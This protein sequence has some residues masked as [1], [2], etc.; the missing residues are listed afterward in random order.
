LQKLK[1]EREKIE[2]TQAQR[3]EEARLNVRGKDV[4]ML[5]KNNNNKKTTD[6]L[7]TCSSK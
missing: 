5:K 3:T 6:G 1:K 4:R 7:I 2:K